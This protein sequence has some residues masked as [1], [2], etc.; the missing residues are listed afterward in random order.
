MEDLDFKIS[1]G[2]KNIIG[3]ELISNDY[4]A[5]FEL[6]KNSYDANAE[7]VKIVFQN[8]KEGNTS[9]KSRILIIDDGDGMSYDD[10]KNKWLFIAYSEKKDS[11][12]LLDTIDPDYRNKIQDKRIFAGAKGIGR[13]SCDRLG[14]ELY[15]YT[16]KSRETEYNKLYTNWNKFDENSKEQFQTIKVQ[17][18]KIQN[19]NDEELD[20][21]ENFKKGT[22][23]EIYSLNSEWDVD[24]LRNLKKYL[25]RLINPV[26]T[27]KKSDFQIFLEAKE[28]LDEDNKCELKG[29]P[30]KIINGIVDNVIF[31][32]LGIKTTLLSCQID[33]KGDKIITELTDKGE[34]IFRLEEKN[35]FKHLKNINVKLF[36][37]NKSAKQIFTRVMGI[38]PKN[39]GSIFLYKNSFRIHPYGDE[40]DDWLGLEIRKGQGIKRNLAT[41]ELMGRIEVNGNQPDIKEVSSRAGGIIQNES[42]EELIK[43]FMTKVLMRLEKYVVEAIDWDTEEFRDGR[44]PKSA[45]KIKEDSLKII[46]K[47]VGQVKDPNK[48]IEFNNDFLELFKKR[49]LEKIPELIK[50]VESLSKYS[51]PA[52]RDQISIQLRAIQNATKELT[53]DKEVLEEKK[54][55]LETE[56]IK[57]TEEKEILEFD[58]QLLA[59][60]KKEKES[61]LEATK[62]ISVFLSKAVSTDHDVVMA[63][64]HSIKNTTY[65]ILTTIE[66]I[67]N[68]IRK[69]SSLEDIIPLID[70]INLETQKIKIL[71]SYVSYAQFE[72]NVEKIKR[73][74]VQFSKEYLE[75]ILKPQ[76]KGFRLTYLGDE[77]QFEKKFNP[78]EISIILNNLVI[79]AKKAGATA[80]IVKFEKNEN[81][82]NLYFSDNG[83]GVKD[84]SA[85]FIF[86]RGYTTTD[87]SGIGLYH[88][89]KIMASMGGEIEFTGNNIDG[90]EKGATFKV[91][92][93]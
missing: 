87:G 37:L 91:E 18:S 62:K 34:F 83:S 71:S 24:K 69:G 26:D 50:N 49:E 10:I 36:Y 41:R 61:E 2:L 33:K 20:D 12:K 40:G 48:K 43:F 45:Q 15:L 79:N 90:L 68:K 80:I 8:I 60:Q 27:H 57:L 64:N 82:L 31:E 75:Q 22:I 42:S 53:I 84:E 13:F 19:L 9:K 35:D 23:L 28:F 14:S 32:K 66:D 1:S 73:N 81:G 6:V 52:A 67:N 86:E 7:S 25:R 39:Y 46:E 89:K 17:Y 74:I 51:P 4:V 88:L 65:N 58:N 3:K 29:E 63:L 76:D 44:S 59:L 55:D 38:E 93:T 78:L 30:H 54:S 85:K 21:I 5:I 11:E 56:K 72:T 47:I 77:I 16:K 92:F 70:E